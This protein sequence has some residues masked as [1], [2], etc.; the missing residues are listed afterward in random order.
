M[1]I[2]VVSEVMFFAGFLSGFNIL[3]ARSA[4]GYWPPPEVPLLAVVPTA[5]VS[6]ALLLSAVAVYLAGRDSNRRSVVRKLRV[7]V[8]LAASFV[9]YQVYEFVV[10]AREG[11]DMVTT[12]YGGFFFTIVGAH[13]LHCVVA[14]AILLWSLARVLRGELSPAMFRAVRVFWYFVVGLWPILYA[15]VYL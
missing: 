13:A 1:L 7:G 14:I 8:L 4:A 11:L 6:V 12:A 15:Q 10:L 2:L 5:V 3:R 9:G